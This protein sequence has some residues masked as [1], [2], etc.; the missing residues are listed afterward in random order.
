[1]QT[2]AE[3]AKASPAA[4]SPSSVKDAVFTDIFLGEQESYLSGASSLEGR[5]LADPVVAPASLRDELVRLREV[6]FA[7]E[8]KMH[9]KDFAVKHDGV[10]YRVSKMESTRGVVFVLRRFPN[11]VPELARL[12]L[13]LGIVRRLMAPGA[14]GLLVI[15][16]AIGSG[17]TTTA[18]AIVVSRLREYGGVAITAEDPPEMPLEGKHENGLCYQTE[19]SRDTG[20]FA[21]ASRYIVRWNPDMIYL[22]EIRDADV[23]CEALRAS[24]N[25]HLVISTAHAESVIKTI[26]RLNTLAEG[27]GQS[28]ALLGDGLFG[29]VHQKLEGK[30]AK[31]RTEFLFLDGAAGARSIIRSGKFEMLSTEINS[32]A[33]RII[34]GG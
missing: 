23:A 29:V 10:T 18:S 2:G 22:G 19:V 4:G 21:E 30:P 25:G 28:S 13:H 8:S 32:Q 7:T 26:A 34:L 33:T 15:S 17:K 1:V 16:G 3:R 9:R 31:L 5:D 12:G 6:C 11:E 27:L 24:I 14:K 20:G